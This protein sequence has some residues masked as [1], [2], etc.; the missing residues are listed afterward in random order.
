MKTNLTIRQGVL[1]LLA[2]FGLMIGGVA[3]FTV[4]YVASTFIEKEYLDDRDDLII[5][6]GQIE[7]GLDDDDEDPFSYVETTA[8]IEA[9]DENFSFMV[10]DS[11]GIVLA[12]AF[13]AGKKIPIKN[14][15]A[16]SRDGFAG[17][18]K[19]WGYECFV[20]FYPLSRYPY[21]LVAVYDYDYVFG[22][23][24]RTLRLF[25]VQML[26]FFLVVAL[27]T[28]FWIIPSLER[29][30]ERRNKAEQE[31]RI[32][33]NL[34]LKAVTHDFTEDP[35]F[36]IYAELR[37]MKDIGGDI[38]LGGRVGD[39]LFFAIG[40]VSDK[41]TAAAFVMFMISSVIR[42]RVQ[43]G[44][45][46]GEM[47]DEVSRLICDNPDYE[48]F[49]TL[50]MG[51]YDPETMELEYCNAGHTRTLVDGEFLDQDPQL[52]A[53]IS[54]DYVYHTQKIRLHHGAH[55]LLYTDGVTEARSE[56][57]SFFGEARLQEWVKQRPACA[58]CREDCDDLLQTL[59]AF[60][61]RAKQNDDI[62]IMSIKIK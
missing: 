56:D 55:L 21:E 31:L 10:R 60:R 47:M 57:R 52:I 26:G 11:T 44:A 42:S 4:R 12:P 27:L 1:L 18:A 35:Q 51:S 54:P 13:M 28:W 16:C 61:G 45:T 41:G 49:C 33:R 43:S 2:L 39:K 38:Y 46:L 37:A 32:A 15:V 62:A 48:M 14:F 8:V 36:D 40:D 7:E 17:M 24:E 5:L 6:A 25:L 23:N 22:D 58:S 50:F 19:V 29:M 30:N 53:G 20:I 34:Q 3:F 9:K 59:S